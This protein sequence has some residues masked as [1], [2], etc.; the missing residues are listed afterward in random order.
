MVNIVN[1]D[2]TNLY[3]GQLIQNQVNFI[4][5]KGGNFLLSSPV[6]GAGGLTVAGVNVTGSAIPQNGLYLPSANTLGVSTNTT[7]RI[8]IGST[9]GINVLTPTGPATTL[10][11]N[12]AATSYALS[13]INSNSAGSSW[14]LSVNA[15]G[16]VSDN[17]INVRDRAGG[18]S[19]L[20]MT[21]TGGAT[22]G[23]ATGGDKGFGT[24]N[25]IDFFKA[26]VKLLNVAT[27]ASNGY[28]TLGGIYFQW[29]TGTSS[30]AG[31]A[32]T[33]PIAFPTAVWAVVYTEVAAA[34]GGA[35]SNT[36]TKTSNTVFT[37]YTGFASPINI[38][39]FAV[40]N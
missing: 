23:S 11:L 33:Y 35:Y 39:W 36:V 14:G 2:G 38:N 16:N 10:T 5:Y 9:G 20:S 32:N 18:T 29:G 26:G 21:G 37:A 28:L 22:M 40:G 15:G 3:A 12:G 30:A 6:G 1:Q 7:E 4:L 25:A 13:L 17:V 34:P 31:S 27:A 19:F 8:A 24:I